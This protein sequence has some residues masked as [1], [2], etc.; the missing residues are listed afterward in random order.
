MCSCLG[1]LST[2]DTTYCVMVG[3]MFVSEWNVLSHCHV[4]EC[5][6][7]E[8][9]SPLITWDSVSVS[10]ATALM[11]KKPSS[12]QSLSRWRH[13]YYPNALAPHELCW[14]KRLVPCQIDVSFPQLLGRSLPKAE[15]SVLFAGPRDSLPRQSR[16]INTQK[17]ATSVAWLT[18][19]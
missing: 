12:F 2:S 9:S 15:P 8:C 11:G 14:G 5:F 13:G 17:T 4:A 10:V 7:S 16:F 18:A 6:F 3:C 19:P 1:C